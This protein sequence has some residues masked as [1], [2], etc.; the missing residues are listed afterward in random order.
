[1]SGS[2]A[3]VAAWNAGIARA[4]AEYAAHPIASCPSVRKIRGRWEPCDHMA[5]AGRYCRCC[6]LRLQARRARD[7][8]NRERR[9][10]A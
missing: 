2:Q 8:R 9:R 3:A 6:A 5:T 1:M 10:R 4:R 7:A